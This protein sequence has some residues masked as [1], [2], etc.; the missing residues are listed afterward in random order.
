M[1]IQFCN[2]SNEEIIRKHYSRA[3]WE[4][5]IDLYNTKRHELDDII[6]PGVDPTATHD[7]NMLHKRWEK[8]LDLPAMLPDQRLR[9]LD[10]DS[11]GA[12]RIEFSTK[13]K[14][15]AVACTTS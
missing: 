5:E 9:K 11:Q 15:I 12:L 6:T 7:E 2:K 14:Y 1:D 8:F 3:P 4:K 10:T 13:G